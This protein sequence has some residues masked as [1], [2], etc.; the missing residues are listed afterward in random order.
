VLQEVSRG[1]A[2]GGG[3]DLAEY[4]A[5]DLGM[6]AYW[7]PAADGQFGNLVLAPKSHKL[8]VEHHYLP[9]G[10]GPM[11]RSYLKVRIGGLTVV[12]THL[13]H[14]KQ[15]TPTRLEQIR[16]ILDEKPDVVVGDLNF[17]PTWQE[18]TLFASAGYFS[19][20]DETS[21]GAGYTSPTARPTNRV[22]WVWAGRRVEFGGFKILSE[23][24]ASD[25]FPIVALLNAPGLSL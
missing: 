22:D 10:Q 2:I 25:H 23:V 9:Y 16:A 5:R 3:L 19:A 21:N 15:N 8:E 1:W 4:L 24:K 12:A 7:A 14:R 13:T 17:W 11:W 18:R 20:Q 6:A